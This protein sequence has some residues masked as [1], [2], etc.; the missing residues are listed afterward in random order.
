MNPPPLMPVDIAKL[1]ARCWAWKPEDRPTFSEV[2]AFFESL[3][4]ESQPQTHQ[5]NYK[6]QSEP[7]YNN[8]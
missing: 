2:V 5:F 4:P 7:L 1:M 3:E 8:N 6:Q